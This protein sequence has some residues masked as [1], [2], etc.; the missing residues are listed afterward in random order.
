M[1]LTEQLRWIYEKRKEEMVVSL[2]A[3]RLGLLMYN[4][5]MCDAEELHK[6]WFVQELANAASVLPSSSLYGTRRHEELKY[7]GHDAYRIDRIDGSSG[8]ARKVMNPGGHWYKRFLVFTF[9]AL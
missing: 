4:E 1:W 9:S 8:S 7:E 6:T 5:D 2:T 3:M